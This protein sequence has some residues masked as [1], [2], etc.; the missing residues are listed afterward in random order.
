MPAP[1]PH[2][3]YTKLYF[4]LRHMLALPVYE[5]RQATHGDHEGDATE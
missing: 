2:V 5:M 3:R 4:I 1:G